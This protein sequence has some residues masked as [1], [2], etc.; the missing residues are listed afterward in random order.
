MSALTCALRMI[1][2]HSNLVPGNYNDNTDPEM[3]TVFLSCPEVL[4]CPPLPVHKHCLKIFLQLFF[5]IKDY[6]RWFIE[7]QLIKMFIAY[8]V[9]FIQ[10]R[11]ARICHK[12]WLIFFV[13]MWTSVFFL[14]L[15]LLRQFIVP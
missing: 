4:T 7:W 11:M 12:I 8:L 9:V 1:H 14:I 5:F 15:I 6:P 3:L 2:K 13:L 10:N